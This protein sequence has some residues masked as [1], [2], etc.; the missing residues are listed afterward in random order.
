M[1]LALIEGVGGEAGLHDLGQRL[2]GQDEKPSATRP[3]ILLRIGILRVQD[4]TDPYPSLRRIGSAGKP[5]HID[6]HKRRGTSRTQVEGELAA[7]AI[8]GL[9]LTENA[10]LLAGDRNWLRVDDH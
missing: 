2:G 9:E 1:K 8:A 3:G 10:R 5:A 4:Y 6:G 7:S